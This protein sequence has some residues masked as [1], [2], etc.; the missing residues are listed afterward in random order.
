[1]TPGADQFLRETSTR[2]VSQGEDTLIHGVLWGADTFSLETQLMIVLPQFC[3]KLSSLEL[4]LWVGWQ[5]VAGG[6][7]SDHNIGLDVQIPV[8]TE[9]MRDSK[10]SISINHRY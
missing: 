9:D 7:L 4:N 8:D 5:V 1:M 2:K 10:P 3:D 6:L